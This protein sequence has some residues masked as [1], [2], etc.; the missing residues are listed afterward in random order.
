MSA[1][2]LFGD[3]GREGY[4]WDSAPYLPSAIADAFCRAR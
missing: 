2:K 3:S 4:E 1:E